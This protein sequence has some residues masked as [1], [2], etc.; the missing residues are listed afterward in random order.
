MW[1]LSF[2]PNT[3]DVRDAPSRVIME[4]LWAAGASVSAYDPEAK[5]SIAA[6]YGEHKDLELC[7]T[8][9]AVL[10]D[11]DALIVVTEWMAFRSPNFEIIKQ[12]LKRP[13]IFDGRNLYDPE[14]LESLG[15]EYYA[16]GR[17]KYS[18]VNETVDV[19]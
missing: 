2:K 15:F 1:G 4:G 17:G 5:N 18:L 12:Q 19:N 9:E 10:D 16:I 3:D 6:V 8:P 7:D 13:I 14:Y 11:A